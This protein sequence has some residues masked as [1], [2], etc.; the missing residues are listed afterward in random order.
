MAV[1]FC[2]ACGA[3]LDAAL[4]RYQGKQTGENALLR[5]LDGAV[6]EGDVVLGDRYFGGYF[7]LALWRGRGVDFVV[8]LH[9]LRRADF[10]RGRRLGR[11][12]HVARWAKPQRPEWL[13]PRLEAL[14]VADVQAY[15]QRWGWK[16]VPADR[17]RTLVFQ[18]P[19]S[20]EE[21]SRCTSSCRTRKRTRSM[22]G[23]WWT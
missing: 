18:E 1:V 20:G 8:R 10:R 13:D 14:R 21:G 4:G 5:T 11:R 23:R 6:G 7:D 3:V 16:S 17:P 2:L 9:Q 12:D 15:L 22:R 19:P